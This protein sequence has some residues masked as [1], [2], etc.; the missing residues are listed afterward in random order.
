[1]TVTDPNLSSNTIIT[2]PLRAIFSSNCAGSK[3]K[4]LPSTSNIS[5]CIASSLAIASY[6]QISPSDFN[7]FTTANSNAVNGISGSSKTDPSNDDNSTP[8]IGNLYV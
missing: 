5:I 6:A 2:S 3:K 7:V 8:Y 4:Y 1:M